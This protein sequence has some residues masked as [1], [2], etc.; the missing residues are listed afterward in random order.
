MTCENLQEE[1]VILKEFKDRH[2]KNPWV[3]G[4]TLGQFDDPQNQQTGRNR[5]IKVTYVG[6]SVLSGN[7]PF[8]DTF[9]ELEVK[10]AY[11]QL[12]EQ[13]YSGA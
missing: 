12:E 6:E 11:K 5:F 7:K 10:Y 13:V 4:I 1:A 3:A 2:F 8:G 9:R